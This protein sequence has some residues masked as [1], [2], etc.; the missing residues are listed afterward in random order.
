MRHSPLNAAL[1]FYCRE[2]VLI[3]SMQ[4]EGLLSS[5][6]W[7]AVF[8]GA[9]SFIVMLILKSLLDLNMGSSFR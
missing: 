9:A 1:A 2:N 7:S 6:D 4:L 8:T 5:I 3:G